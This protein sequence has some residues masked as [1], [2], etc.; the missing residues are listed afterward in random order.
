M[1]KVIIWHSFVDEDKPEGERFLGVVVNEVEHGGS[2]QA[3]VM[4][5]L[6]YLRSIGVNPG[7]QVQSYQVSCGNIS[8]IPK[9]RWG[10]LC[11]YE[12]LLSWGVIEKRT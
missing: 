6:H 2:W 1:S 3:T 10:T 12:E 11:S 4:S 5:S 7:G 9:D 8:G